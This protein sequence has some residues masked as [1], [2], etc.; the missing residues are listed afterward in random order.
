MKRLILATAVLAVTALAAPSM[1]RADYH[2]SKGEAQSHARHYVRG[3][4]DSRGPIARCRPQ[5]LDREEPGYI[6]HRWVCGWADRDSCAGAV[7]I[8]G[9]R[10]RG[11]Y[12]GRVLRGMECF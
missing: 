12:Y 7:L 5:N 9:S 4:Y 8:I 1:A 11:Y 2:I 6:Y 3:K 10:G